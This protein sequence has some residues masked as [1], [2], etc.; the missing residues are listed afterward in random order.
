MYAQQKPQLPVPWAGQSAGAGYNPS[1]VGLGMGLGGIAGSLLQSLFGHSKNPADAASPYYNQIPGM[2]QQNL[3]G[4]AQGGMNAQKMLQGQYGQLLNDPGALYKQF[5]Q[6]FQADPGYEFQKNQGL[7]AIGNAAAAGGFAGTPQHQQQAGTL[8]T[9]L[10]NQNF[11]DYM[12][13]ILGLYGQGLSGEQGLYSG[14]LGASES[15]ATNLGQALQNQGN[16]AMSGQQYQNQNQGGLFGGLGA[17]GGALAGLF[18]G[19]GFLSGLF[20]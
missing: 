17:L 2:L 12:K 11:N 5:G 13:N 19:G 8:A 14:G 18:P 9:N 16:L 3:G 4:Y 20:K 7:G 6:G 15:L 10:A 1:N